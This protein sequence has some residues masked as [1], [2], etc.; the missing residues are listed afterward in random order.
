MDPDFWQDRW[1][2]RQVG[3]HQPAPH[4]FLERWWPSLG[5]PSGTRVYVP[6]CG[7]SLDMVWLAVRGYHVVG[8][9]LSEIAVAEFFGEHHQGPADDARAAEP[10]GVAVVADLE[11]AAL[12][13]IKNACLMSDAEAAL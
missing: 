7:K 11:H 4:P 1:R 2:T 12:P 5:L 6:L 10:P 9:E 13:A 8:S 3:F